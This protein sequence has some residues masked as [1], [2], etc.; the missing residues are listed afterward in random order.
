MG[1]EF[2]ILYSQC[3][4][5]VSCE[6]STDALMLVKVAKR[7]SMTGIGRKKTSL[8]LSNDLRSVHTHQQKPVFD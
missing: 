1:F 5:C 3:N 4:K 2:Y 7:S 8:L 6:L